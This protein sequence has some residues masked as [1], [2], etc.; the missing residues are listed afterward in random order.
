MKRKELLECHK[1][2]HFFIRLIKNWVDFFL[3]NLVDLLQLSNLNFI[4]KKLYMLSE[5]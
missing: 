5:N 4:L 2:N 1:T 3:S